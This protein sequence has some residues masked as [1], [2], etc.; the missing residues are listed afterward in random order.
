MVKGLQRFRDAFAAHRDQFTLIG[1][2]AASE[3]F[4]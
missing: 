4:E 2:A 1:G 3:W